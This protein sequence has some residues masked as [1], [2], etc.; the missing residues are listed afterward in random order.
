[1]FCGGAHLETVVRAEINAAPAV[2]TDM[3][4][5]CPVLADGANRTRCHTLT[6]LNAQALFNLYSASL[7]LRKTSGGAGRDT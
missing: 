2:D 5:T 6:T 4:I 3:D 1:M 7:A